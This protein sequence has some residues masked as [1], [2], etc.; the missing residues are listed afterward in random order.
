MERYLL[1]SKSLAIDR[2]RS[3]LSH[4]LCYNKL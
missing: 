2:R 1:R 3:E 4:D